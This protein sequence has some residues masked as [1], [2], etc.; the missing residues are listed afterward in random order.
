MK[1][2]VVKTLVEIVNIPGMTSEVCRLSSLIT[3]M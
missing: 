2:T 3:V 1:Q